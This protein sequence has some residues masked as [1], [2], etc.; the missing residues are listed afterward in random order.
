MITN[1]LSDFSTGHLYQRKNL[2]LYK[3][4]NT[5]TFEANAR[6]IA[7]N[8]IFARNEQKMDQIISR[9]NAFISKCRYK[10]F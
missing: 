8:T 4:I 6:N 1:K 5:M 10:I 9:K 3:K 7:R 2:N